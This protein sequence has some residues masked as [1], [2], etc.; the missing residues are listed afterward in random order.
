MR[1]ELLNLLELIDITRY[2][3]DEYDI[4]IHFLR[5]F[6]VKLFTTIPPGHDMNDDGFIEKTPGKLNITF[7][8]ER[9]L[10]LEYF[11]KNSP[12]YM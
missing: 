6:Q 9:E 12:E 8:N 7:E 5:T 2:Y 4:V 3:K 1:K 10:Y 11:Y